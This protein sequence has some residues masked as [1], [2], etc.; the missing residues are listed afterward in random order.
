MLA[1]M[2]ALVPCLLALAGCAAGSGLVAEPLATFDG[3]SVLPVAVQVRPLGPRRARRLLGLDPTPLG[4]VAMEVRL[5]NRAFE[6]MALSGSEAW[7]I[8][9]AR[10]GARLAEGLSPDDAAAALSEAI[11]A[12]GGTASTEALADRLKGRVLAAGVL[13]PGAVAGGL[14]YFRPA[15]NVRLDAG[16]LPGR[17]VAAPIAPVP[18]NPAGPV[19]GRLRFR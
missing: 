10:A 4:V 2:R 6:P 16:A 14:V 19:G 17:F 11:R 8:H 3:G 15:E 7:A 13:A 5:A 9:D 18:A 12:A 1:A